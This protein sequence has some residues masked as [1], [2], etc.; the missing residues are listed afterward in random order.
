MYPIDLNWDEINRKVKLYG[1]K[2]YL[3]KSQG[4]ENKNWFKN[5]RDLSGSQDVKENF[6]NCFWKARCI[7]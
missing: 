5:R 3:I 1:T 7:V 4:E 6:N 2:L